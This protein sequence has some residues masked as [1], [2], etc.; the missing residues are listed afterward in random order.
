MPA[1]RIEEEAF[2][3]PRIEYLG[4]LLGTDKYGAL[5]RLACIWRYCTKEGTAVVDAKKLG[6][7]IQTPEI[8]KALIESDLAEDLGP[9]GL[10]IKGCG[11]RIEWYQEFIERQRER[12]KKGA[13]TRWRKIAK[14]ASQ[15]PLAKA[16]SQGGWPKENG[17]NANANTK[18]EYICASS[19]KT[20]LD[21]LHL[22]GAGA[23][24]PETA[25]E[26]KKT[27]EPESPKL[28]EARRIAALIID[29]LNREAG[30]S[31]QVREPTVKLV[32]GLLAKGYTERDMRLVIVN[33]CEAWLKDPKMCQYLQP[34]TL[35]RLSKFGEYLDHAKLAWGETEAPKSKDPR[36]APPDEEVPSWVN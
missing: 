22:S 33:R 6:I 1:V 30:R 4:K 32:K 31:F 16:A 14:A 36:V 18:K 11:G 12:G 3:D 5:G 29:K 23:P 35:F 24:D 25:C 8:A 15:E 17:T 34:S 2:G 7:F 20:S 26:E 21:G 10:R 28:A 19:K 9:E 13:E 27:P